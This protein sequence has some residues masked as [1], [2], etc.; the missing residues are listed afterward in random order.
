MNS[1]ND[2]VDTLAIVTV[3]AVRPGAD[4]NADAGMALRPDESDVAAWALGATVKAPAITAN[5]PNA[6]AERR[7]ALPPAWL[8][9]MISP[10]VQ[11]PDRFPNACRLHPP[12]TSRHQP[13][14]HLIC[15]YA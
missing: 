14:L 2:S 11:A 13:S 1:P 7:S 4:L 3:D 6:T 5:N 10:Y 15:A 12:Q 8:E 9:L